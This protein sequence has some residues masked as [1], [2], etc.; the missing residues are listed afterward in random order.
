MDGE[1]NRWKDE[2]WLDGWVGSQMDDLIDGYMGGQMKEL[3]VVG[4]NR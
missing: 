2:R 3:F 1:F 4:W